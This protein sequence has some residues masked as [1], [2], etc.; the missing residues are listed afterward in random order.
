MTR[1]QLLQALGV[2]VGLFFIQWILQAVL[3]QRL[4]AVALRSRADWDNILVKAA[5]TPFQMM[6]LCFAMLIIVDILPLSASFIR[7]MS[8]AAHLGFILAGFTFL[9]GAAELVALTLVRWMNMRNA[10]IDEHLCPL[11]TRILRFFIWLLGA[12]TL[13]QNMGYSIS[14]VPRKLKPGCKPSRVSCGCPGCRVC[15]RHPVAWA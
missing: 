14:S 4:N 6:A 2:V 5:R 11:I 3:F 10:P 8:T 12:L 15:A 1:L 7:W 13:V 9:S